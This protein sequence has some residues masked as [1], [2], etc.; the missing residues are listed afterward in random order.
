MVRISFLFSKESSFPRGE[1][2]LS[3]ILPLQTQYDK[4]ITIINHYQ[5]NS[6]DDGNIRISLIDGEI[7]IPLM[8]SDSLLS[9]LERT[10]SKKIVVGESVISLLCEKIVPPLRE[11][12]DEADWI[13]SSSIG[14]SS[15][16]ATASYDRSIRIYSLPN[17]NIGGGG[18]GARA[19]SPHLTNHLRNISSDPIVELSFAKNLFACSSSGIIR[20]Y[21]AINFNPITLFFPP[22]PS[23]EDDEIVDVEVMDIKMTTIVQGCSDGSIIIYDFSSPSSLRMEDPHQAWRRK[24]KTK[25]KTKTID[26]DNILKI[27]LPFYNGKKVCVGKARISKIKFIGNDSRIL[28]SFL[29][30][31]I[32]EYDLNLLKIVRNVKMAFGISSFICRGPTSIICCH[33][34]GSLK[35]L[36]DFNYIKN[37]SFIHRGWITAIIDANSGDDGK[38]IT[39]GHDGQ[40]ILLTLNSK[41]DQIIDKEILGEFGKILTLSGNERIFCCG[42]EDRKVMIWN[43]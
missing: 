8:E 22:P 14:G 39:S 32:I 6:N 9:L 29:N 40:L 26:D 38:F 42:G 7:K 19:K 16:I 1:E 15:T 10:A 27:D 30:G 34:N 21:D 4:I 33:T 24:G 11:S 3:L 23:N 41:N 35:V 18:G 28:I 37:L 13:R 25:T 36:E 2:P 43:K 17:G 12:I 5:D 31:E 20:E